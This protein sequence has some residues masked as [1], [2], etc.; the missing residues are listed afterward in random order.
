MIGALVENEEMYIY[1]YIYIYILE[2]NYLHMSIIRRY[3]T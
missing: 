3:V 1:I 2:T